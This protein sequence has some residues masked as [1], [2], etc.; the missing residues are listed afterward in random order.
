MSRSGRLEYHPLLFGELPPE[1]RWLLSRLSGTA[2]SVTESLAAYNPSQALTAARDFFRGDLCDWYIE[3]AKPREDPQKDQVLAAVLD[4][5]LRLLHPFI[6]VITEELWA[7]LGSVAPDRGIDVPFQGL[8]PLLVQAS[9]PVPRADWEDKALEMQLERMRGVITA[10][11]D[12]RAR[13]RVKGKLDAVVR[14][15]AEG[16]GSLQSLQEHVR[17]LADLSSMQIGEQVERPRNAAMKVSGDAEVFVTGLFDPAKERERLEKEREQVT[18][19]LDVLL[20][21]LE[22]TAFLEKAPEQAAAAKAKAAELEAQLRT[23]GESLE[24]LS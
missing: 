1:D 4:Q 3:I 5:T 10:I 22:N 6:P 7:L 12:L 11:R 21:R 17:S 14:V 24:V 19:Q 18:K 16:S 15:P 23:L 2:R 13:Y 8:T 9:W 20:K